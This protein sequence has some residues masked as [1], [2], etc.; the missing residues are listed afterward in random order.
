MQV[1]YSGWPPGRRAVEL[2]HK[3]TA[4]NEIDAQLK[5]QRRRARMAKRLGQI[6]VAAAVCDDLVLFLEGRQRQIQEQIDRLQQLAIADAAAAEE[7]AEDEAEEIDG[8]AET[9]ELQVVK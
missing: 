7:A 4:L 3:R 6:G 2:Q 5:V 9:V 1:D 8:D